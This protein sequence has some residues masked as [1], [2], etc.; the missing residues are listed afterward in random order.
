MLAS[1]IREA[2]RTEGES[3][4]ADQVDALLVT[5][6]CG[7]GDTCCQSFYTERKPDEAYGPGHRSVPLRPPHS[8]MLILDVVDD[9]IVHVEVLF[10]EPLN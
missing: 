8:W 2:L 3:A 7:C 4:L 10:R 5:S 6:P 1:E 9:R